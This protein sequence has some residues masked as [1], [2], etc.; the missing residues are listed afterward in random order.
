MTMLTITVPASSANIGP[1]FDSVGVALNRYLTLQV[2]QSSAWEFAHQSPYLPKEIDYQE[3]LIYQ[4]AKHVATEYGKTLPP[5][6]VIVQSDIPLARGLGSS[7]S[8]VV[9]GIE[10]ANQLLN[11]D[12]VADQKLV[13]ST[14][15]EGHPD[16]VAPALL[17]GF[18]ISVQTENTVDYVRI[19]ELPLDLVLYIP[20]VELKTEDA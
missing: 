5:C 14:K 15:I 7:A 11:L 9:A 12:L 4:V 17:G 2:S 6:K 16:N 1:G 18:I 20:D 8:A 10:L 13:L 3:H 19:D